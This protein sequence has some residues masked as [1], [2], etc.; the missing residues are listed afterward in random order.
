MH[1]HIFISWL[2]IF[3]SMFVCVMNSQYWFASVESQKHLFQNIIKNSNLFLKLFDQRLA[4][5]NTFRFMRTSWISVCCVYSERWDKLQHFN[6]KLFKWIYRS[7]WPLDLWRGSAAAGLLGLWVRIPP[8]AWKFVCCECC[9]L[10]CRGF[11]FGP[12]TRPEESYRVW[13]AQ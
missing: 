1:L 7:R 10:S 11:C 12:I 5:E 2:M 4:L 9:A 3:H 8:G 6:E 13:C